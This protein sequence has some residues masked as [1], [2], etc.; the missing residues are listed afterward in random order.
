MSRRVSSFSGAFWFTL[1]VACGFVAFVAVP[2]Q[3]LAADLVIE[4][5]SVVSPERSSA[6]PD[7]IVRVH[8]GRI[9]SVSSASSRGQ[10]AS[11][12]VTVIDGTGLFLSPGLIDSHVHLGAIPGMTDEQESEHPGVA[13]AAREQIPR[14]YLLSGFTTLID[15]ISTP[16]RVSAWRKSSDAVPDTYFC[17]GAALMDGYSMNYEPAPQRYQDWPYML[18]EPGTQAPA[19]IDPAMHTPQAVVSRMRRDGAICVKTFY[20][21]GFAGVS[22][23]P[24]PKLETIRELV[25]AAHTAGLPVLI[26]A[27]SEEAQAFALAAGVDI[28]AHG[29]WN[30]NQETSSTT[31]IT[32]GIQKILDGELAANIGWQPTLQVLD[33]IRDLFDP[34]FL[35]DPRLQRVLPSSLIDW[36]RSPEGGWFR[37]SLAKDTGLPPNA[38]AA[39]LQRLIYGPMGGVIARA[40][41]TAHYMIAHH[42]RILFGTDTPSAPTYANPPGLNALM[43]MHDL[44]EAGESPEQIFK[45]ATLV[46]AQSLKLDR[47]IGTVQVGKRANLLL[48]RRDPTL[49]I[50][51]YTDIA[52]VILN[53]R[54]LDPTVLTANA[55]H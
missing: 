13:A 40:S 1:F 28:V 26:H 44:M 29:L 25:K 9:A 43:E 49:T 46:N 52:K 14:S 5:V 50:E 33:G 2:R 39:E 18:M 6:L 53:G 32:P 45:S 41:S 21:R 31:E 48:L 12:D 51:A 20:E 30:W 16:E 4:H 35:S 27:N 55:Q 37:E 15:L 17:G 42:G 24:V 34:A 8:D 23:L 22:N 36:C 7:A 11:A 47:D 10:R 3:L 54:V 19:G 38:G